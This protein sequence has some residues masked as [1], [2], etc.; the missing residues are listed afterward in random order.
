MGSDGSR[1]HN[2]ASR[3]LLSRT[4]WM[5]WVVKYAEPIMPKAATRLR[6][7]AGLKPRPRKSPGEIRGEAAVR[8]R[9]TNSAAK[10]RPVVTDIT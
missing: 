3:G 10:S 9:W 6:A 5:Y 7:T 4:D 8:W 1:H 2:A